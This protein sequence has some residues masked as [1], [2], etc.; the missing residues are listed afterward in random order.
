M[1]SCGLI[2]LAAGASTR[3]GQPK[4]L[5]TWQQQPMLQ[6]MI[7]IAWQA[8]TGPMLVVLGANAHHLQPIT[9]KKEAQAVFNPDWKEGIASSIRCGLE[10]IQQC[11]QQ[12]D[13]VIFMVCDQPYVTAPLLKELVKEH[14]QTG[15]K[16]IASQYADTLGIPALFD[17]SLFTALLQLK[18]DTGAKKIMQQYSNEV[19]A[20]AFPMGHI[21]ID[22]AADYENLQKSTQ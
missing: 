18:G 20:V 14:Q 2:I 22:T 21:D 3:L 9:N 6:H 7:E 17:K 16:I 5:L 19:Q 10:A 12:I 4:Q 8:N 15:K 1:Y 13:A 11:S